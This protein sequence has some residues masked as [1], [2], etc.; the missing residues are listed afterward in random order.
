MEV[1]GCLF[2]HSF[3]KIYVPSY[4]WIKLYNGL[5]VWRSSCADLKCPCATYVLLK[6][7]ISFFVLNL[8]TLNF[9]LMHCEV[10]RPRWKAKKSQD[11]YIIASMHHHDGMYSC[12]TSNIYNN[13]HG[14]KVFAC[15]RVEK[16]PGWFVRLR[17]DSS[18]QFFW[19]NVAVSNLNFPSVH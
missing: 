11:F 18:D 9:V 8:S 13:L 10:W 6:G 15:R 14:V 17:S 19:H 2:Y 3:F 16:K 1:P 12:G 4:H 7:P 5:P